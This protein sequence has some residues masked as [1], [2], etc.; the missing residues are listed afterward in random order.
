MQTRPPV[1]RLRSMPKPEIAMVTALGIALALACTPPEE[2]AE[3]AREAVGESIA[4][5]DREAALN[6]IGEHIRPPTHSQNRYPDLI[7]AHVI[8]TSV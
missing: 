6:A 4:R 5:G 2:R 8:V 3:Q 1:R 7:I